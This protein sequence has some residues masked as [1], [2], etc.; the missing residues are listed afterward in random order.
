MNFQREEVILFWPHGSCEYLEKTSINLSILRLNN[1][2][3]IS[4]TYLSHQIKMIKNNN[5]FHITTY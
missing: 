1:K 3:S 4:S 2:I 5:S